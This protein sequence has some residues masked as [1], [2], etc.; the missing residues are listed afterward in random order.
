MT[1]FPYILRH[2]RPRVTCFV[3]NDGNPV[4]QPRPRQN[5]GMT[6]DAR[7]VA[8]D[9]QATPGLAEL[10]LV[11]HGES[12]GNVADREANAGKALRLDADLARDADVDLSPDGLRQ[13]AALGR[14]LG[15]LSPE[16][17]PTKVVSSPYR[18][19]A[20]TA[21]LATAA[22][23]LDVVLD[24]RLRERELGI[25]DGLTWHGIEKFLPDEARR[26]ERIGKFYYR[27]PGGESW[28]DVLLRVRSIL[29][30][31]QTRYA[32]ER[33]W[34]FTHEAVVMCFRVVLE[35]LGEKEILGIQKEQTLANCAM[36]RYRADADGVLRLEAYDDTSGIEGWDTPVTRED[37][38]VATEIE[39]PRG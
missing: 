16:Q 9:P 10:V 18:R 39:A 8:N 14:H 3:Q 6:Q 17:Y 29:A 4:T 26:R 27:P 20:H 34:I 21:E 1:E 28:C 33:L 32:G 23:P 11:R 37:D 30:E 22:H 15:Q 7:T 25:F 5:V 36:T 24:E 35:G 2:D 31:L 38:G 13:A 12:L 19:A